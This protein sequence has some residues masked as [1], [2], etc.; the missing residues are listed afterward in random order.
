[1]GDALPYAKID[2]VAANYT[3]SGGVVNVEQEMGAALFVVEGT[4]VSAS[5]IGNVFVEQGVVNGNT[6]VLVSGYDQNTNTFEGFTGDFLN[7]NGNILSVEFATSEGAMVNANNI[8]LNFEVFQN[9]P[10]PFNPTTKI[11]F[12]NPSNSAWNVTIYN[13]AGQRVDEFAGDNGTVISLDWDA[14]SLA[15]GVYFYKVV[16]GD[17][18]ET[19]KAVLLK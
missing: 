10:N 9:Y 8:P 16:A 2:A 13:V 1:V 4:D 12:T 7:L 11:T 15:S 5:G 18:V 19:K 17:N 6:H 3:H 14:S